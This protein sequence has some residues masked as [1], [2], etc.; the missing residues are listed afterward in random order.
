MKVAGL[1][2][3]D[4]FIANDGRLRTLKAEGLAILSSMISFD[5]RRGI[6]QPA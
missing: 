4:A 6:I 2:L 1:C 3:A 5:E